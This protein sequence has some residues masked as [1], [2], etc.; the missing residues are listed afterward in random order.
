MFGHSRTKPRRTPRRPGRSGAFGALQAI[1]DSPMYSAPRP[2]VV[3]TKNMRKAKSPLLPIFLIVLVDILGLTII[4]PLLP[5]YAEKLGAAPVTVGL[6]VSVYAF[7]QL[8]SGPVLG[9]L[10]DRTGRK[11]LLLVSQVGTFAGFLLL[12]NAT[13]LTM[14]FVSRV[15][16][17]LTAGNL[18]L[19]QAYI[20]DVT[21]PKNRAKA[22]GIIGVA[23]GLGFLVGPAFSGFLSQYGYSYPI[24]AAAAL[25]A[26]S[27]AATHW[28]LP[29]QKQ[30]H[31]AGHLHMDADEALETPPPAGKRLGMLDWGRYTT[32]FKTPELGGILVQFF[33]FTLSFALFMSGFA[34]FAERRF[35]HEGL[36]FGPK[37]VGYVFAYSGFLGILLQGGIVGRLVSRFGEHQVVVMGFAGSLLGYGALAFSRDLPSLLVASTLGSFGSSTLRPALTSLVTQKAGRRQ[38]GVVLGLTQSLMSVSQIVAPVAAGLLIGHLYLASWALLAAGIS[39]GGLVLA[40][41]MRHKQRHGIS[42]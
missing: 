11:P 16:D 9:Q 33:F 7:C 35:T 14:V 18:S 19:A 22:F 8:I 27:I 41:K 42:A 34:L 39:A 2:T 1:A 32:F 26:L 37:E 20:S 15:I 24:Y 4:L 23:F 28:L 38:Q 40:L 25:S 36:P 13:T 31:A 21:A 3:S 12:A 29:S 30:L 10:S 17:G 5:F 6:L